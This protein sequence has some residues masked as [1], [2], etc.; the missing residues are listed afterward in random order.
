MKHSSFDK[1]VPKKILEFMI[2]PG[3]TR[4][5]VVSHLQNVI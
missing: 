3:L 5:N 4:E 2:V 1:S